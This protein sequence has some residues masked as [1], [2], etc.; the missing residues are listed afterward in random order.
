VLVGLVLIV[1]GFIGGGRRG[2]V[3]IAAGVALASLASLELSIRE[4]LA[5]YRSHS[6]LLAAGA[7]VVAVAVLFFVHVSRPV[8]AGVGALVFA[9]AFLA[10]RELFRRRSGGFGFR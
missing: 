7:G 2:H 8:L 10:L 5:G 9:I 4:H 6:T 1:A 3:A